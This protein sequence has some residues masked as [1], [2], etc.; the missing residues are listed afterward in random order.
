M[1]SKVWRLKEL[2]RENVSDALLPEDIQVFRDFLRD[3]EGVV[4][5]YES[6]LYLSQVVKWCASADKIVKG[7]ALSAWQALPPSNRLQ[8]CEEMPA[9]DLRWMLLALEFARIAVE[10][11]LKFTGHSEQYRVVLRYGLDAIV[12]AQS[13]L[14]NGVGC[15]EAEADRDNFWRLVEEVD[16]TLADWDTHTRAIIAATDVS[17]PDKFRAMH[18]AYSALTMHDLQYQKIVDIIN[19]VLP[20]PSESSVAD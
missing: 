4:G 15:W 14:R 13:C 9:Q 2:I 19:Q 5:S 10:R 6:P 20:D 3:K 8:V 17:D 12:S 7:L 18:K 1:R 11:H 16:D